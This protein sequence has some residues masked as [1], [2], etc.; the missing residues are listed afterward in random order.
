MEE[1]VGAAFAGGE[2]AFG[3]VE[4][5]AEAGGL[6]AL[7][8]GEILVAGGH[9]EAVGFAAG[10]S[11]NDFDGEEE[12]ADHAADDAELLGVF[13]AEDGEVGEDGVEELGDDGADAVEMAGAGGAAEG[14][15]EGGFGDGDA[16]ALGIHVW[17]GGEENEIDA[18]KFAEG[19]VGVEGAGIGGEIL[20][21][22]ELGGVDEDGDDHDVGAIL[23]DADEG[24]VAIVEVA[25]GGD[26]A[27]AFALCA[28]VER[29]ALHFTR[30]FDDGHGGRGDGKMEEWNGGM[31]E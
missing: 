23:R 15:G 9:G 21:G 29:Q 24:E 27:D 26:E 22:A 5:A 28:E 18:F 17:D 4:G 13:F 14:A 31:V 20:V 8:G 1:G 7:G 19:A 3:G 12:V 2:E 25:H 6:G 10:G 11:G 30:G 16:G